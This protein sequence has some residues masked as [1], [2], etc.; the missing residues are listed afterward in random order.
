MGDTARISASRLELIHLV[1]QFYLA[2]ICLHITQTEMLC[3]TSNVKVSQL[4]LMLI[5]SKPFV[6]TIEVN[7]EIGSE[8]AWLEEFQPPDDFVIRRGKYKGRVIKT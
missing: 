6:G 2:F 4:L 8:V 3:L 5:D 1:S 7:G